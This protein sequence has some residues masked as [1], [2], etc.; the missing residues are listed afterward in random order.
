MRLLLLVLTCLALPAQDRPH[1]YPYRDASLPVEARVADLLSRMT[2][3]EK[4]LQLTNYQL[5]RNTNRNNIDEVIKTHPAGVGTFICYNDTPELRNEVQRKA[6]EQ[7]RWGI[8]VLFGFDIIHGYRTLFP[9]PLAQAASWNRSLVETSCR[10]AAEEASAAGLDWTFSPMIDIARDPRWGRIVEGYGEDPYAAS[11]F[12]RAAVKGYQG[13]DLSQENTLAACL[14]HFVGYGASEAGRDYVFSDYSYQTLR[15]TYLPPYQAGVEAGAVTVMSAFNTFDGIP[16]TGNRYLLREILK[17]EWGFDG[18]VV[19][20]WNAVVQLTYAGMAEDGKDA[21]RIAL[22][23]G[24]DVDMTD[25]LYVQHLAELLREGQ[26][27]TG[28]IDEAVSRVLSVKFRLGLFEHPFTRI[29]DLDKVY[30]TPEKLSASEELAAQSC[31][32][33][34]NKGGILP[35]KNAGTVAVI[36]PLADSA[37]DLMGSWVARGRQEDVV[38]LLEGIRLEF[39]EGKVLYSKGCSLEEDDRSLFQEAL[40]TARASDVVILCLGESYRWSGENASRASLSLPRVQTALLETLREAGKPIVLLLVNGRPL[41]LHGL[42]AGSD[43]ILEIWQPGT[44]GGKAVAGLLSGRHNP[45]GKLPVTFPHALGQVP[46][47]YNRHRALRLPRQGWYQDMQVEPEYAFGY[48][49]SYSVFEY[50]PLTVDRLQDGRFCARVAVTNTSGI[51]G[52]ETVHWYVSD[53]VCRIP[54]PEKELKY[55]EK[56]CI[57][58]GERVE[59][60]FEIDPE[61]DLSYVSASGE[62]LLEK[63]TFRI[64]AGEA[65]V[66]I[67][68]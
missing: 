17:E 18:F 44:M 41:E 20:D 37:R 42:A 56:K 39:G 31:V 32:L 46:I 4:V 54:R 14:K 11:E 2:L 57:P 15:D 6:L 10:I 55:F 5:G 45:S 24:V 61:R 30:L 38:T 36:G 12:C 50:G 33:L 63:G 51:D 8:P 25:D 26:I 66:E 9:V 48:G 13:D 40:E 21:A 49:L 47:Y 65:C 53:P 29:Q 59:F 62:K 22:D 27:E 34:E 3:E 1:Q 19:S 35:L 60:V 67:K 16:C 7:T 23:A 43:A 52:M 64:M 28:L 58:A 68:L